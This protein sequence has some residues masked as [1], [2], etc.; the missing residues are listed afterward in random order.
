MVIVA[1]AGAKPGGG[2]YHLL[3]FVP[4]I[5]SL[6]AAGRTGSTQL[7]VPSRA[8]LAAAGLAAVAI[9]G[10]QQ[11]FFLRTMWE[12]GAYADGDDLRGYLAA[13]PGQRVQVGHG[14]VEHLTFVRP[15]AVF[16]SGDYFVDAPAV[17]EHQRAGLDIPAATLE[18][19]RACRADVW[20][21]PKGGPPFDGPNAYDPAA[22][23]ALFPGAF[24]GVFTGSYERAG[25]TTFFDVW[26]CRA[27]PL[28]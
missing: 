23:P 5:A 26:R 11:A 28:R 17:Q 24:V 8:T 7:P 19:L 21:L 25:E 12:R 14:G 6:A 4:V 10:L 20:L 2:A 16:A 18:A 9:A 15:L 27:R 13:H 22:M 3:P 1:V